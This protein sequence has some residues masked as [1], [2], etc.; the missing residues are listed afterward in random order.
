MFRTA[1]GFL[2][3]A[4]FAFLGAL[5][6]FFVAHPQAAEAYHVYPFLADA[7]GPRVAKSP[8]QRFTLT[9]GM[10]FLL[11][12]LV[13]GLLLFLADVGISA[14]TPLWK[15]PGNRPR[16]PRLPLECTLTFAILSVVFA[17]AVGALLHRIAH[18]GELPGGVNV[19]PVLVAAT[20]FA[21][22]PPA[23]LLAFLAGLP[24]AAYER[25]GRHGES[26]GAP[27]T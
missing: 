18:G 3:V 21:V 4:P 14:A 8:W 20:P 26:V 15:G 1:R 22:L 17:V 25:F 10:F 5:I 7:I 19:A 13:T 24:R 11:P 6:A 12:Y 23:L 2:A 27:G 9:T 16:P